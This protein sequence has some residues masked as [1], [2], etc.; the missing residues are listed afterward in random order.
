MKTQSTILITTI[1]LVTLHS[2][3]TA[4][5]KIGIPK[6]PKINEQPRQD[7]SKQVETKEPAQNRPGPAGSTQTKSAAGYPKFTYEEATSTPKLLGTTIEISVKTEHLNEVSRFIPRISF[8]SYF[9]KSTVL[10]YVAEWTKPNGGPW[11]TEQLDASNSYREAF[12][13]LKS[14]YDDASFKQNATNVLGTYGVKVTDS[15]SGSVVFQGKFKVGK[16]PMSDP[17]K[18]TY[19]LFYV[20]QDWS[21]SVGAVGLDFDN[22]HSDQ[23]NPSVFLW[24]K[25]NLDSKSFEARLFHN[26]AMVAS[27][28]D[29][30]YVNSQ[31]SRGEDC[32][33][34]PDVCSYKLWK[35]YW[36][37]FVIENND[38]GRTKYPRATFTR[39]KPGDYTVKI[40]YK[41]VQVRELSFT[42]DS[43][44]FLPAN[45]WAQ[46]MPMVYGGVITPV[47]ILGTLDKRNPAGSLTEP[48]Y[49]NLANFPLG[50]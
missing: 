2:F 32:F 14:P 8:D 43:Q 45:P 11:F 9:D 35:F 20:D 25:G 27:T 46:Y 1:L 17:P 31:R 22:W 24:F 30:G 23:L 3:G 41:G 12:T 38:Y 6:V 33:L 34:Q 28:D 40:F 5:I 50:K 48:L 42:I 15:K 49:G 7:Q 13:S 4:Q 44:G 26:G 37:N 19:S 39:D 47:K 29:G 16:L 21:L 36:T 18:P 10:R